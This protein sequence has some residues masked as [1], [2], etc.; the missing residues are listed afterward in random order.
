MA[1]WR[2]DGG[3]PERVAETKLVHEKLLEEELENWIVKDPELLGEPLFI[4]GRQVLIPDTKDR[5]DLLALDTQ[6]KAVIVELKRGDLKDPVDVQALRY[7]SYIA[8]WS[9]GEF[10]GLAQTYR[11]TKTPFQ[12]NEAFERFCEDLQGSVPDEINSD[13]RIIIAGS[14]VREK[15]GSVAL[16]LREHNVDIKLIEVRAYKD[17]DRLLVEPKVLVP[18]EVSRFTAVGKPQPGGAPW[19][20][21]G[22]VWHLE[23]RCS[24]KTRDMLAAL[25]GVLD[26]L[27]DVEGPVWDQ[28]DYV[29]FRK[30]NFN[31][32][33]VITRP[34]ML[35]L[36]F[37]IK[38]GVFDRKALADRL[39]LAEF[40]TDDDLSDKMSLP[41]S[42]TV[43]RLNEHRERIRIRAKQDFVLDTPEFRDFITAAFAASPK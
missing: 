14:A 15:L 31:W 21:D 34:S 22:R 37:Y 27:V 28:K 6:G 40:E 20:M 13:Q 24:P 2:V 26:E 30:S 25:E 29:A 1:I 38:P 39:K 3:A 17:G 12:F 5:L 7:A 32:L 9:F 43:K 11:G 8:K 35:I 36:D 16:W 10:E 4:V 23:K 41:S 19:Q 42:V 33:C 18:M